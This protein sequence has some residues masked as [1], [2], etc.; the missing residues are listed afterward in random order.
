MNGYEKSI[1]D[2]IDTGVVVVDKELNIYMWNSWLEM[3]TGITRE[4]AISKKLYKILDIEN[5]KLSTLKRNI[6][7]S[8]GLGIMT[9]MPSSVNG[10]LIKAELK[11]LFSTFFKEM[12]QDV[13]IIPIDAKNGL[14][15]IHIDD[16]TAIME[17]QRE[18]EL[19]SK[20]LE[21]MVQKESAKR[22]EGEKAIM[23]K[24]KMAAMGEMIGAIAHQ[25]RQPLN[26]LGLYIQDL[27]LSY[28]HN[29]MNEAYVNKFR[30]ES[31][32]IIRS[33]SRTIDDFRNFFIPNKEK[34]R[35]CVE[36]ALSDTMRIVSVQLSSHYIN[37][38][39]KPTE[40]HYVVGFK[41]E[42]EQ[43]FLNILSNAKD[44]LSDESKKD[45][46]IE[47]TTNTQDDFVE[48]NFEDSAGGIEQEIMG[49]IFEPYFTTKEQGKG[50]GIGLYMSKEIV[51]RHL[52]GKL[53]VKNG[54]H[55]ARFTISLPLDR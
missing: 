15:S 32:N 27:H 55:G 47:I 22:I 28:M 18:L 20:D 54:N 13:R 44:A 30:T 9:F 33:M 23:E 45:K 7:T 3:I 46:F 37:T 19:Y 50:T 25:W 24:A 29:D 43:V 41:N 42:L 11:N 1:I 16:H 4:E 52:G 48:I 12:Q 6:N 31:M 26:A 39:F 40:K 49:R 8:I 14:V 51:E 36:D 10:Y 35:F 2:T 38:I 17:Y 21:Q 34:R 53:S 5:E